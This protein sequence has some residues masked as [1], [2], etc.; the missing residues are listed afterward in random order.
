MKKKYSLNKEIE[1]IKKN[2][3]E[4]LEL[5]NTETKIKNLVDGI[6]SRMG[7]TEERVS[8]QKDR[9]IEITQ[10]KHQRK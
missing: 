9:I 10:S 4:I 6:N 2:K 3:M 5:K 7:I 1:E 8:E